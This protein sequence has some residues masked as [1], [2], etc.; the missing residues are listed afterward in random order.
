MRWQT[1]TAVKRLQCVN[2]GFLAV[3]FKTDHCDEIKLSL[4]LMS[5][6][7]DARQIKNKRKAFSV[8]IQFRDELHGL[9]KLLAVG[10]ECRNE[11]NRGFHHFNHFNILDSLEF[12]SDFSYLR[13]KAKG[14]Q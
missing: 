12:H 3:T 7:A 11:D 13:Y 2:C 8:S 9:N 14:K 1:K 6:G 10:G 5:S 4:I